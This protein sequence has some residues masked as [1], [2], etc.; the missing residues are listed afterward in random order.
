MS[1]VKAARSSVLGFPSPSRLTEAF[2]M[3]RPKGPSAAVKLSPVPKALAS[4]LSWESS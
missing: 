3:K 2:L 4:S 1:T